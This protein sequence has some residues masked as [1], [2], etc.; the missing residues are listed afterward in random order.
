MR[1]LPLRRGVDA[2]RQATAA[3]VRLTFNATVPAT[4]LSCSGFVDICS[5]PLSRLG[6]PMPNAPVCNP[7]G[8]TKEVRDLTKCSG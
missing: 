7:Y 8:R 2:L 4:G 1:L 6:S 3:T 5:R